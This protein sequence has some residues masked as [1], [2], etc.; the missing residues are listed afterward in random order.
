MHKFMLLLAVMA[1]SLCAM[2]ARCEKPVTGWCVS[3]QVTVAA[4]DTTATSEIFLNDWAGAESPVI[5]ALVFKNA[6]GTGTGTVSF[7][8]VNAGIA[9]EVATSNSVV[10]GASAA[11]WPKR[12]WYSGVYTNSEPYPANRLKVTVTQSAAN[13]G[14]CVYVFGACVR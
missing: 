8:A 6:Q 2:P 9:Y 13:T 5:Q 1:A 10:P 3:N 7:S 14:A 4:G 11:L 12:F